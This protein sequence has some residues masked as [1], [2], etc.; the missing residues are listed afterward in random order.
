[1][2]VTD[3]GGRFSVPVANPLADG[4]YTVTA[5]SVDAS[6]HTKAVYTL[7][8]RLVIDTVGPKVTGLQFDR[9]S[10]RVLVTFTD[11]RS[12]LDQGTLVDGSNYQFRTYV[13][14][15]PNRRSPY[16]VTSLTASPAALP[17]DPQTV[18]VS[19]K[20]GRY[21]PGGRYL[22]TVDSARGT[23]T[24]AGN[25]IRDV[26][27]NALDGE[28]YGFFRSGN[29]KPGGDFV[30]GLDAIQRTVFAPAPAGNGYATPVNPPG[31]PATGKKIPV[32]V[33]PKSAARVT[34]AGPAH[35]FAKTAKSHAASVATKPAKARAH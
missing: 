32:V 5:V 21:L 24:L 26:A 4:V 25:G 6:G 10:G 12:G 27:G 34:P 17:T 19:I 30:A 3:A 16:F 35:A 11:D 20:N 14:A 33:P 18:A 28:F 2:G 15:L 13:P 29:N 7:P 23:G 1:M 22:L 8:Q 9:V 31:T